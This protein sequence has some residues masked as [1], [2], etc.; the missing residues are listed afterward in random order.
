M[1]NLPFVLGVSLLL[2]LLTWLLLRG[3]DT[4]APAYARTLRAFDDYSLAEASLQRD[5]LQA[6]TGLLRN[7]D[8]LTS[9]ARA[10]E[11]AV[12]R[13][14]SYAQAERLDAKP[15]DRLAAA[16]IQQEELME[17]FKTSNALLQNSLSY[18]GLLSTS[19]AFLA[20]DAQLAPATGA[21]AAAILHLS[22]DTSSEA[23]KVL[24]ERIEQFT[25][26]APTV[27]PDA[28]ASRAMLAHARLLYDQLPAVDATLRA[29]IAV[30]TAQALEETRA[31]F[32][33]H[34]SMVEAGEQRFRLLLYLV[35]CFLV[36]G[37]V[38]AP[39]H[40]EGGQHLNMS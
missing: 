31:M 35:S 33:Y 20:Q 6:R 2:A 38:P 26:Q 40:C 8:T 24:Q 21:L 16:V 34:R 10:I 19:P 7:Y 17:R 9:A 22:R 27:G 30:P 37:C 39:S 15:V 25:E 3:I 32:S 13:L 5:V 28:E 29:L 12:N 18:V 4:N 23:L 1:K 36:Y 11:D 14:R